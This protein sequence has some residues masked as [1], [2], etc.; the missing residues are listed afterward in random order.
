MR[1]DRFDLNLLVVLDT[2]LEERNVTRASERLHIGQSAGSAALR[3]LRD[4]FDDALLVP[5]GRQL[6][7]TPLAKDLVQ[8]VREALLKARQAISARPSFD[9]S[10]ERREFKLRASDYV[11]SQLVAPA[12]SAL[13]RVAPGIR[14]DLVRPGPAVFEEFERGNFELLI[15]PQQYARRLDHPSVELMQD[16]HVCLTCKSHPLAGKPMTMDDYFAYGHVIVRLGDDASIPFE[17]WFLP[18]D[19]HQRQIEVAVDSFGLVPYVLQGT[20]RIATVHRRLA[21]DAARRFDVH[22]YPAPFPVRPLVEML[23]W[24]RHLDQD[25]AHAFVRQVLVSSA[26]SVTDAGRHAP[27]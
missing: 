8:P 4:H 18:R 1:L 25:P 26:R 12:L 5:V 24:P 7:L 22:L 20:Q 11:I 2:L 23:F 14:L 9:P 27:S 19:G 21:E 13:A 6:E 3:R 17:E 10:R 15:L 16:D